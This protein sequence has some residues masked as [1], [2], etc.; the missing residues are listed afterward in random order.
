VD[1]LSLLLGALLGLALSLPLPMAASF[2]CVRRGT[3][4][5]IL[6]LSVIGA[7]LL[8]LGVWLALDFAFRREPGAHQ[9]SSMRGFANFVAWVGWG[10]THVV[11]T[12]LA[13]TVA[14][15]ARGRRAEL[16]DR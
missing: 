4:R 12:T 11:A 6:V 1:P 14:L 5:N 10:L 16:R 9:H 7:G 13:L 8:S 15:H 2:L 3:G